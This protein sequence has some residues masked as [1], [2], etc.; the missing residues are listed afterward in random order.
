MDIPDNFNQD[1]IIKKTTGRYGLVVKNSTPEKLLYYASRVFVFFVSLATLTYFILD[2][3]KAVALIV[4]TGG[5][6]SGYIYTSAIKLHSEI[7]DKAFNLIAASREKDLYRDA[8]NGVA[9][10]FHKNGAL[11]KKDCPK[12]FAP[13]SRKSKFRKNLLTTCNF[14]EEMAIA[15]QYKEIYEPLICDYYGFTFCEFYENIANNFL[16]YRRGVST[17]SPYRDKSI[18]RPERILVFQSMEWLYVRW[19]PILTELE[20]I[21]IKRL[22]DVEKTI[23]KKSPTNKDRDKKTLDGMERHPEL[24][25]G[26]ISEITRKDRKE[27]LYT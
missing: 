21:H 25:S 23:S 24:R 10:H 11:S 2:D 27:K 19:K 6:I 13:N 16:A 20:K 1:Y 22:E 17:N 12:Y 4:G 8:I 18:D 15:I 9:I 3:I 14:Y 7:R 5:A 26:L